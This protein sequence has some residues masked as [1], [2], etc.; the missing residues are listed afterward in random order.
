MSF[1]FFFFLHSYSSAV[2]VVVVVVVAVVLFFAVTI[3]SNITI[4]IRSYGRYYTHVYTQKTL[5]M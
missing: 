3:N 1:F 4:I 5:K 2:V